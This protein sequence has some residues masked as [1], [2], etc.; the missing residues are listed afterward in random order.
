M[1]RSDVSLFSDMMRDAGAPLLLETSGESVDLF[2]AQG[3]QLVAT[4]LVS[5]ERHEFDY[6]PRGRQIRRVRAFTFHADPASEFGGLKEVGVSMKVVYKDRQGFVWRYDVVEVQGVSDGAVTL[7][8]QRT[9][10]A[11]IAREGALGR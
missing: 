7:V 8:G 1:E 9:S 11:Q 3:V 10:S 6:T 5:S 4:A 2:T